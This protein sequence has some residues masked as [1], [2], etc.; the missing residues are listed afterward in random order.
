[1]MDNEMGTN[2]SP[3]DKYCRDFGM[4]IGLGLVSNHQKAAQT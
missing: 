3:I 1:M 4:G 2:Q